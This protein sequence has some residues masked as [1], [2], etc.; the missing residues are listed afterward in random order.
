MFFKCCLINPL[1][2]HFSDDNKQK[3]IDLKNK[4]FQYR[5]ILDSDLNQNQKLNKELDILSSEDK[6]KLKIFLNDIEVQKKTYITELNNFQ[7]NNHKDNEEVIL[8]QI[9][10]KQEKSYIEL[11]R[12]RCS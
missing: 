1:L 9:L 4:I 6:E 10:E 12:K 8:L 2:A 7:T 3:I 5:M 11:G